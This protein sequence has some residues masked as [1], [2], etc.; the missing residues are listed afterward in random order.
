MIRKGAGQRNH[1]L[2]GKEVCR[3]ESDFFGN[4]LVPAHGLAPLNTGGSPVFQLA[5]EH[6]QGA[7]AGS[8][9]PEA[10]CVQ[11]GQCNFQSLTRFA[12]HVF[13]RHFN[14]FERKGAV[15]NSAKTH[16]LTA[17]NH[18]NAFPVHFNDK[19]GNLRNRLAAFG[20]LVGRARHDHD[21]PCL[22]VGAVGAPQFVTIQRVV[23]AVFGRLGPGGH[24]GRIRTDIRLRQCES[25]NF[26]FGK[27]GQKFFLLLFGTESNER[28]RHTDA[29]VRGKISHRAA[30]IAAHH[31]QY[32]GIV[33]NGKTEPAVL[34]GDL[35]AEQTD[36]R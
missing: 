28:L 12:D 5:N 33:G 11:R 34:F 15:R 18:F 4:R 6:F 8:R 20:D 25:G 35:H 27:A 19:G 3:V 9:K 13:R 29:L 32:P 14:V 36:L 17:T 22:G 1:T 7:D 23:G 30:A 10:A 31:T 26:P 24:F 2:H 21:Q 16:K